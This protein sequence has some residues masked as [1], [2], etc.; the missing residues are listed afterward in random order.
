MA[1]TYYTAADMARSFRT[2]RQNTIQLASDIPEEHYGHRAAPE[3]RTVLETLQHIASNTTWQPVLHGPERKEL[4]TFEDFGGLLGAAGEFGASLA[5]KAQVID[6]LE[7]EG[8]KFASWI[9]SLPEDVLAE[10]VNFPPPLDP[11]SKTRFEMLLGAKEHEM[12][13]RGQLMVS[14]RQLGITPHLTARRQAAR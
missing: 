7:A 10:R 2:V 6:A 14:Q 9:E 12:H 8:E 13:H 4:V 1:M 5:T 11:S 3:C